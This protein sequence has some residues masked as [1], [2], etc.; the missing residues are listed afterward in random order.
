VNRLEQGSA[1]PV[2]RLATGL[3]LRGQTRETWTKEPGSVHLANMSEMVRAPQEYT[4]EM[5]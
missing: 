2:G 4:L 3:V 5:G 1:H